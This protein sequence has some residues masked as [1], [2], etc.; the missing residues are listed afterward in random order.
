M[1]TELY[2]KAGQVCQAAKEGQLRCPLIIRPTS[3]D[4][5]TGEIFQTLRCLQPRW[6]LPQLLNAAV[7]AERFRQ[8]V[9]RRLTIKLWQNQPAYPRS[10]LPWDEGSTQVDVVMTWENPRTTVFIEMKYGSDLAADTVNSGGQTYPADQLIR[11]IRVGLWRCGWFRET[12]LFAD[13]PRDFV[14][15]LL[16]PQAKHPLVAKYREHTKLLNAIPQHQRLRG[17][18]TKPFVGELSYDQLAG[19]LSNN[20]RW[21]SRP[22]QAMVDQL[23]EYLRFKLTTLKRTTSASRQPELVGTV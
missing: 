9:Y 6:W 16:T 1:L 13:E 23:I 19:V 20:R 4:V 3:E 21:L 12:G 7:G 8:Q 18:P 2:G 17:L 22:E 10:L 5:I 14:Q 11:N 15:V